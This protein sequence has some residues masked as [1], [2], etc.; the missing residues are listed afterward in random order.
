MT[1]STPERKRDGD[2]RTRKANGNKEQLAG[3]EEGQI[4]EEEIPVR[5]MPGATIDTVDQMMD[6]V[7]GDH[8]HHNDGLHLDGGIADDATWQDY[9]RRLIFFPGQMYNLPKGKVEKRFIR[10]IQNH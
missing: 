9:W 4:E 1:A 6:K 10:I 7:F 3:Q 5:D 8:V 2:S